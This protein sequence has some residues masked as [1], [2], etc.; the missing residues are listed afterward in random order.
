MTVKMGDEDHPGVRDG[1]RQRWDECYSSQEGMKDEPSRVLSRHVNLLPREGRA[2]VLGCG[3][4]RNVAFLSRWLQVTGVDFSPVALS[5]AEKRFASLQAKG[6]SWN[7]P[8]LVQEEVSSFLRRLVGE[9]KAGSHV[10]VTSINF[11]DPLVVPLVK[12]LLAPGGTFVARAFTTNDQ[13]MGSG[14]LRHVLVEPSEM[15]SPAWFGGY[16]VLVHEVDRFVDEKGL[17]RETVSL[18]ARKP[19]V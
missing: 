11:F 6:V 3:T 17:S 12:S 18:V 19:L 7:A 9:G 5:L 14:P 8:V 1:G 15:L 10:L 4:G 16:W 2:L 13:R